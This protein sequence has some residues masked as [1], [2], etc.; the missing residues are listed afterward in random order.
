MK[1]VLL[2]MAEDHV[3]QT[4]ESQLSLLKRAA[5]MLRNISLNFR[6]SKDLKGS[7]T[8]DNENALLEL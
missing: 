4:T 1:T 6:Q 3:T 7:I 5:T 2:K 8:V